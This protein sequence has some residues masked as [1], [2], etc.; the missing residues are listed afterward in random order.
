MSRWDEWGR[1]VGWVDGVGW[2]V[3][4]VIFVSNPNTVEVKVLFGFYWGCD[5]FTR[6]IV[7]S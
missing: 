7:R 4:K 3:C 6:S 1:W 2:L 5:N